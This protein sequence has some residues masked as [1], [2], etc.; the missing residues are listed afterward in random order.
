M[1]EAMFLVA[2]ERQAILSKFNI[3]TSSI[4][5]FALNKK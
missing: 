4:D 3:V 5:L 1:I 2:Y